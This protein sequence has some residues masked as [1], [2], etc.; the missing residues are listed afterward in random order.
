VVFHVVP[1]AEIVSCFK[2][3][4]DSLTIVRAGLSG[5]ISEEEL[6]EVVKD[7]TIIGFIAGAPTFSRKLLES[8]KDLKF[9]QSLGVGFE[10][11]DLKD[12]DD[13]GIPVANNP[14]WNSTSVAEHTLMLI[15][16]TLKKALQGHSM[17]HEGS[18]VVET[19]KLMD[20]TLELRDK[21]L[22]II[23]LGAI[24][25]EVVRLAKPFGPKMIYYKRTRLPEEE[26]KQLG[27]EYRSFED[28]LSE[29]D[30]VSI[31]TP[32]TD[33]TRGMIGES[34][35]ALMR[36][37]A[38]IINTSR[39]GIVD[40]CAAAKALK[41]GKLSAAGF[42]VLETRVVDGVRFGDSP[43]MEC[44]NVVLTNHQAGTTWEARIRGTEQWV[45]NVNRFLNGEKPLFLLNNVWQSSG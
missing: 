11:I 23:G 33:E 19:I 1:E 30:I 2:D 44:E 3:R 7:A 38:I 8:C 31:H 27:V 16:M 32:L 28:L 10:Q 9:I 18:T 12:A 37:G 35:M 15:L 29:S 34:E 41:T 45:E 40:E 39:E 26:E 36:D 25:R 6:F 42:D 43:L 22:G 13:L 21:T 5:D 4:E 20:N 24:G 17:I 14:G